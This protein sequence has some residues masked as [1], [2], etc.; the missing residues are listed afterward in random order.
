M[1]THITEI[2]ERTFNIN[3]KDVMFKLIHFGNESY[4]LSVDGEVIERGIK[5]EKERGWTK[6]Y[7]WLFYFAT[8]KRL[9]KR[10]KKIWK[11]KSNPEFVSQPA[12]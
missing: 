10:L 11:I 5:P 4:E 2:M 7:Y 1:Y 9:N 12:G 8:T 6:A 3:G